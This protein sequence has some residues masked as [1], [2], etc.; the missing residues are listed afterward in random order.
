MDIDHLCNKMSK[1]NVIC[2]DENSEKL[3][4]AFRCTRNLLSDYN[5]EE[6]EYHRHLNDCLA[7][8]KEYSIKLKFRGQL[9]YVSD[10]IEYFASQMKSSYDP[11]I[12]I[13]TVYIIDSEILHIIDRININEDESTCL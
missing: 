9:K 7:R 8:Y 1:T 5:R 11:R 12:L 13:M 3:I 2:G 4:F 6:Y 10:T